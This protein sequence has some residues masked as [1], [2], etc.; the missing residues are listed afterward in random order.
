M[1]RFAFAPILVCSLFGEQ[2]AA[3]QAWKRQAPDTDAV[4]GRV[5][6]RVWVTTSDG[7]AMLVL[8]CYRN[9]DGINPTI[10]V[11]LDS[12]HVFDFHRAEDGED[13]V[14]L[15]WRADA[16][17]R[18]EQDARVFKDG[19]T[20]FLFET[21]IDILT[22]SSQFYRLATDGTR[23]FEVVTD[24]LPH[25]LAISWPVAFEADQTA[26]WRLTPNAAMRAVVAA[27]RG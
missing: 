21:G 16:E 9:V 11:R 27:C 2:P 1:K 15:T 24:T 8:T 25:T 22:E 3:A 4:S 17:W 10:Q 14:R 5:S 6:R 18:N 12:R 26:R 19:R 13:R 7:E 20:A 23:L